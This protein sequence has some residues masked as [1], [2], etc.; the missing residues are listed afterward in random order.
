MSLKIEYIPTSELHLNDENV[1][2]HSSKSI[3]KIMKS[4]KDFGF[5]APIVIDRDNIVI[6]GNGRLEASQRLGIA[7]LPCI[8]AEHLDSNHL[9]AFAIADNRVADESFFDKG[10][11]K[12]VVTEL[13]ELNFDLSSL[14]F[15]DTELDELLHDLEIEKIENET[16]KEDVDGKV[17]IQ[18]RCPNCGCVL[19]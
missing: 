14:G 9:K 17:K 7:E 2:I 12:S 10:L 18:K 15:D 6:A 11:L 13:E 8:R 16:P 19:S 4:I 1:N 5:L 3:E